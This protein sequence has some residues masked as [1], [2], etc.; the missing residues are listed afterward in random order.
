[1]LKCSKHCETKKKKNYQHTIEFILCWPP[2]AEQQ[3]LP[4]SV[5]CISRETRLEKT[6]VSTVSS[7]Q[8]EVASG[9]RMGAHVYFPSWHWGPVWL[10]PEQ[11]LWVLPPS[12]W[13]HI[14]RQSSR[15]R[16]LTSLVF[17]SSG[18]Y[19]LSTWTSSAQQHFNVL[20]HSP[21]PKVLG[22]FSVLW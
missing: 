22:Q 18:S 19:G 21:G 13:V 3:G 11:A 16:S 9:L 5:A 17:P 20:S 8:L 2:T 12:L 4:W 7:Y 6:N 15:V 10:S 14:V 1:M